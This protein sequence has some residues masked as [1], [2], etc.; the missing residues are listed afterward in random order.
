M[1]IEKDDRRREVGQGFNLYGTKE[2]F[3][4]M[5]HQITKALNSGLIQGWV[6]I[7]KVD[8]EKTVFPF[9]GKENVPEKNWHAASE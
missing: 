3:E 7:G 9:N 5:R 2:E 4:A 6:G 8:D 1:K